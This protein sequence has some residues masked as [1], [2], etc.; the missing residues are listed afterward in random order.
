MNIWNEN[1]VLCSTRQGLKSFK[2]RKVTLKRKGLCYSK[3]VIS[4]NN[5][6]WLC[7]SQATRN[8]ATPLCMVLTFLGGIVHVLYAE[9]ILRV[10]AALVSRVYLPCQ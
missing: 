9:D 5:D 4:V 2:P 1:I 6:P 8:L 7:S 3:F 10:E